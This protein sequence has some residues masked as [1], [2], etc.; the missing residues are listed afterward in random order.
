[1]LTNMI[2]SSCTATL[3]AAV[4]WSMAFVF[5]S[6]SEDP[7]TSGSNN[8]QQTSSHNLD[9]PSGVTAKVSGKSIIVS[10]NAVS[11]A[12]KY[13]VYVYRE[14]WKDELGYLEAGTVTGTS[15]TDKPVYTCSYYYKVKAVSANGNESE[16]CS[17][18]SC[19]FPNGKPTGGNDDEP[20]DGEDPVTM[21]VKTMIRYFRPVLQ[22]VYGLKITG[23]LSSRSAYFMESRFQRHLLQGISLQ[24]RERDV[25]ANRDGNNLHFP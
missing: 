25:L 17:I 1:M 23:A 16:F 6:C 15:F 4:L 8:N 21:M 14:H 2:Q 22:R 24:E 19:Y 13:V 18:A 5:H 10:W 20:G 3:F 7:V 9:A 11:G 12:S